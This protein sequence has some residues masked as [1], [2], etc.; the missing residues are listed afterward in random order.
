M[1]GSTAK[2]YREDKDNKGSIIGNVRLNNNQYQKLGIRETR[3]TD[4]G[5][6]IWEG[7]MKNNRELHKIL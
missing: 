7:C 1:K 4:K 2:N 5:I 3:S 6:F